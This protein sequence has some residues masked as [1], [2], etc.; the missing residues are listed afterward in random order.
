MNHFYV[1]IFLKNY[2]PLTI[3]LEPENMKSR[4]IIG[5]IATAL[6]AKEYIT[7]SIFES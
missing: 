3:S 1:Y 4:I 2:Q 5:A 7:I 6:Y